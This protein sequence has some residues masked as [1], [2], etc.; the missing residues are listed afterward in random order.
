VPEP[1]PRRSSWR[2]LGLAVL[3]LGLGTAGGG[4]FA[5]LGL[6]AA[7][8]AGSMAGVAAA[9][10]A[11]LPVTMPAPLRNAAF[12]LLGVSMG[13]SVT[14][15]TVEQMRAW[16]LSL[17]LLAGSVAA[18]LGA[19]SFYLQR[20]HG[21]DPV[22][23]RFAS[24]P[25]ALSSVLVLAATS[26][27]DLPRVALA[28]SVRLF[29]LVALM[30]SIL[31]LWG[32]GRAAARAMAPAASTA[33]ELAVTLAVGAALAAVL[34]WLRVPGG[35]LLGAM[36]ASGVLHGTGIVEGRL[37]PGILVLGFVA[38]GAVIGERFRGTSLANLRRTLPGAIG[39]VLLALV[40]SAGFAA[41]GAW[42]LGLSFGQ[43]WLAYAPGGVEAM[44]IMALAL[45]LDPAFVGAH[46]V[47]RI[48]GL[49]L[50]SPLWRRKS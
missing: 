18:T 14:P 23:A 16:P 37:P 20:V 13:A 8:L 10:L 1:D 7:W 22:T 29:T 31:S 9:A 42:W 4:L 34:A 25:G 39:S 12:V 44:A 41:A 28:Q 40:L 33:P 46:H 26:A 5:W 17:A 36:V 24:I 49:N 43:L 38:T 3:T 19:G 30:P 15:E 50:L 27:A 2:R 47:V 6:P 21:W 32:Q 35:V 11:G 48:L 45:G